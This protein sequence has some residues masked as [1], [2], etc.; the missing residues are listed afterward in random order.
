MT[1]SLLLHMLLY[2][3]GGVEMLAC[4]YFLVII[5]ESRLAVDTF[6]HVI[7]MWEESSWKYIMSTL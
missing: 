7:P 6:G 1:L 3:H 2:T 4:D 5:T